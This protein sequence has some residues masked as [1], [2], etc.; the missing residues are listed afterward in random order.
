MVENWQTHAII[1]RYNQCTKDKA[2]DIPGD[3]L[4]WY[5]RKEELKRELTLFSKRNITK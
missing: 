2:G 5:L 3:V 4:W 1:R